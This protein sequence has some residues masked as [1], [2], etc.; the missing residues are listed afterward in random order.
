MKIIRYLITFAICF[1]LGYIDGQYG[2]LESYIPDSWPWWTEY[3][4]TFI[5][6]VIIFLIMEGLFHLIRAISF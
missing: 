4:A 2:I 1:G 3:V 6:V 5:I